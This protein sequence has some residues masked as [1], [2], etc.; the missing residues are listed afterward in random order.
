M[1]ITQVNDPLQLLLSTRRKRPWYRRRLHRSTQAER[2]FLRSGAEHSELLFLANLYWIEHPVCC[3]FWPGNILYMLLYWSADPYNNNVCYKI[4]CS[5]C[6]KRYIIMITCSCNIWAPGSSLLEPSG[7]CFYCKNGIRLIWILPGLI[8][9][10]IW[11]WSLCAVGSEPGGVE[12]AG[13][14]LGCR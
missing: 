10:W 6:T 8:W 4:V 1:C 2:Q 9:G 7:A 11:N 3:V 12:W 13:V 5:A 14:D